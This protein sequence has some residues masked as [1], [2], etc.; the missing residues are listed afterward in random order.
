MAT[1]ST[2]Q[3]VDKLTIHKVDS[4]NTWKTQYSTNIGDDDL[5][6]IPPTCLMPRPVVNNVVSNGTAGQ[7]LQTDGS[8]GVLWSDV[9]AL[10][11]QSSSTNGKFL[12]SI[13]NQQGNYEASWDN[14]PSDIFCC[15]YGVTTLSEIEAA[16]QSNKMIF[17]QP[18]SDS[19]DPNYNADLAGSIFILNQRFTEDDFVF[20]SISPWR[21]GNLETTTSIRCTARYDLVSNPTGNPS[22]Q[23]WYILQ[24]NGEYQLTEDTS[25]VSGVSYYSKT[26]ATEWSILHLDFGGGQTIYYGICNTTSSYTGKTVSIGQIATALYS[27]MMFRILFSY[28]NSN[29]NPTLKINNNTAY[30]IR[31]IYGV[32]PGACS[33]QAGEVLDFFF[34]EN[35]FILIN[36]SVA[37]RGVAGGIAT[38]DAYGKVTPSQTTARTISFSSNRTL[39]SSDNGCR[40]KATTGDISVFVPSTLNSNFEV[41]IVNCANSGTI[42]IIPRSGVYLNGIEGLDDGSVYQTLSNKYDVAVLASLTATD[43]LIKGDAE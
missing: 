18:T 35:S 29:S 7:F 12:K 30:P 36:G 2:P 26:N 19:S 17:V 8:G 6:I 32:S 10:P 28:A 41:E 15:E 37:E 40:L 31:K 1:P 11:A 21:Y 42:K 20:H 24:S 25:V 4:Y 22:A 34:Y 23:G 5:I 16:Y 27:G 39:L 3:L 13:L 9:D 14:I 38:L 43:W 33:W